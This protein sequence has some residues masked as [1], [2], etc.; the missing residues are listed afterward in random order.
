MRTVVKEQVEVER[1]RLVYDVLRRETY[2]E[3]EERVVSDVTTC[4]ICG[5]EINPY[6]SNSVEVSRRTH[7]DGRHDRIEQ[8]DVCY[9]CWSVMAE[10]VS[11]FRGVITSEWI[12]DWSEE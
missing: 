10:F 3:S 7:I 12:K 5:R 4:D 9:N 8:F 1:E 11:G 2:T 6:S